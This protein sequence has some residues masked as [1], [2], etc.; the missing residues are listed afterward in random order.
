MLVALYVQCMLLH[1][2][3]LSKAHTNRIMGCTWLFKL[4]VNWARFDHGAVH[5]A[6]KRDCA[7]QEMRPNPGCAP[8]TIVC[9][10][11]PAGPQ[12]GT[13]VVLPGQASQVHFLCYRTCLLPIPA[14]VQAANVTCRA[15]CRSSTRI[16]K[17]HIFLPSM[18]F[19][20]SNGPSTSEE[21]RA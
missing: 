20:C 13:C 10:L 17:M 2:C 6:R 9:T 7:T 5:V 15:K 8:E 12:D 11:R 14:G 3:H 1:S 19:L 4:P 21:Q 16:V 18:L